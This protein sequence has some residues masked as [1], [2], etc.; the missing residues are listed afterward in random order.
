MFLRFIRQLSISNLT[1]GLYVY[2]LNS[3]GNN[4]AGNAYCVLILL[5]VLN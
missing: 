2:W 5:P 1:S 3:I 4:Y